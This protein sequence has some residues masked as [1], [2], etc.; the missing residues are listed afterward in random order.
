LKKDVYPSIGHKDPRK[1]VREDIKALLE[2]MA[3]RSAP[4]STNKV[5]SVCWKIFQYAIDAGVVEDKNPVS[6]IKPVKTPKTQ[7]YR[8]LTVKEIGPFVRNLNPLKRDRL[9]R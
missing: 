2:K 6:R 4:S 7:S 3:E 8:A 1:I 5:K 9:I